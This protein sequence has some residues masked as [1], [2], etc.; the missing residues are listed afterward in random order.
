MTTLPVGGRVTKHSSTGTKMAAYP[1]G[2]EMQQ[3]SPQ[4]T[5]K[6]AMRSLSKI[7]ISHIAWRKFENI[8]GS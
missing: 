7:V 2:L 1:R 5:L 6:V 8:Y 3:L 4:G